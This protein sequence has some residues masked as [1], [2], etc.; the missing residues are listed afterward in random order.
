MISTFGRQRLLEAISDARQRAIVDEILAAAGTAL[1]SLA[2]LES[3]IFERRTESGAFH[4]DILV[5]NPGETGRAVAF[6][7]RLA[8][9]LFGPSLRLAE[10]VEARLSDR[11]SSVESEPDL[12]S[13]DFDVSTTE[14]TGS[15]L[16]AIGEADLDGALVPVIGGAAHSVKDEDLAAA[17]VPL[18]STLIA[19]I[20]DVKRRT[21]QSLDEDQPSRALRELDGC[22]ES[23]EEA[24][25]A[26]LDA[27]AAVYHVE[28]TRGD[29][30]PGY[31]SA[32]DDALA[33]RRSTAD[34]RRLVQA[35]NAF[36]QQPA[37]PTEERAHALH[38]ISE[39][40]NK[41]LAKDVVVRMRATDR[42]EFSRFRE[43]LVGKDPDAAR[44]LAEGFAKYLDS[45][46]AINDRR[47]LL[48]HDRSVCAT[49]R[50][51][52]ES[53]DSIVSVSEHG[54]VDLYVEA[55]TQAGK[56]LGY[57]DD[58]DELIRKWELSPRSPTDTIALARRL[59]EVL[60][61]L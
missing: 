56:L 1:A 15:L 14:R 20:D 39:A 53:G 21:L 55:L 30:V 44:L 36:V 23:L 13:F 12:A 7:R 50:E 16:R 11:T 18:A 46:S 6:L 32:L 40:L 37:L 29:L 19:E 57:R 38:R 52:I 22:R 42:W 61:A 5:S 9:H 48:E 2:H 8:E 10:L 34:L 43:E 33:I 54:A 59:R 28:I 49:I 3:T 35:A 51:S 41:F 60:P 45:L 27:L 24:I 25:G 47:V 17:L 4:V 26:L 31:R 58:L